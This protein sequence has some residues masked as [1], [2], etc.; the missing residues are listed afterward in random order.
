M[1]SD[2][3]WDNKTIK[4]RQ[5]RHFEFSQTL[6][7]SSPVIDTRDSSR[8]SLG[9]DIEY[10]RALISFRKL[11]SENW[12]WKRGI[13]NQEPCQAFKLQTSFFSAT[14]PQNLVIQS[15]ARQTW[16]ETRTRACQRVAYWE[17]RWTLR[18]LF[19]L[20]YLIFFL[21]FSINNG[22]RVFCV[23][24]EVYLCLTILIWKNTWTGSFVTYIQ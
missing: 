15:W 4:Q 6:R 3:A 2:F 16:I 12:S 7:Q 23:N 17:C 19:Y 22:H 11:V 10:L 8:L 1:D 24:L 5:I 18:K 9:I 21:L 14:H 13:R 20:A